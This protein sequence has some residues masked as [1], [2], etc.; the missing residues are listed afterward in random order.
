MS[1]N[2]LVQV[3]GEKGVNKGVNK[4]VKKASAV[5]SSP[6][7]RIMYSSVMPKNLD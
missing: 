7:L 6:L 5:A 1:Q 4:V 2:K 3:G